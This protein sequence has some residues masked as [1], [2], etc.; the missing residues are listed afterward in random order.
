MRGSPIFAGTTCGTVLRASTY[1][2]A[3]LEDMAELLG[4]KSLSMTRRYAYL[5]RINCMRSLLCWIRMAPQ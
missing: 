5:G 1:E 2:G 4:H 3:K